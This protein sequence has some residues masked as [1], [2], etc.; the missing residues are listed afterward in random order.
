MTYFNDIVI[1]DS[2]I[3]SAKDILKLMEGNNVLADN[4]TY[5]CLLRAFAFFGGI[6]AIEEKLAQH[7][8][9]QSMIKLLDEDILKVI[10]DLAMYGH[11]DKVDSLIKYINH[12]KDTW[13]HK[14]A[15]NMILHLVNYGLDEI[16]YKIL[17]TM[18]KKELNSGSLSGTGSF[19]VKHYVKLNRP[20]NTIFELCGRLERD[21][22]NTP[23]LHSLHNPYM[24]LMCS[25]CEKGSIDEALGVLN[26]L[27]SI[28]Y[29]ITERL[30]HPL[31]RKAG[32]EQTSWALLNA[33]VNRFNIMP[34]PRM[35]REYLVSALGVDSPVRTRNYLTEVGISKTAAESAI[36]LHTLEK[37]RL[38]DA[39]D[40]SIEY[41]VYI[42]PRLFEKEL[43]ECLHT[44]YDSINFTRFLRNYSE[45]NLKRSK[46]DSNSNEKKMENP[47]EAVGRILFTVLTQIPPE[48]RINIFAVI[49]NEFAKE[50][51]IISREQVRRIIIWLRQ[52]ATDE[53]VRLLTQIED[54]SDGNE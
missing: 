30:F 7:R 24:T 16:A 10:G 44:K 28:S 51:L 31:F 17:K 42:Y 41:E 21:G 18:D 20:V 54:K 49:L 25:L 19:L 50:K 38:K 47:R 3:R 5:T 22:K 43:I 53:I 13:Y 35:V 27:K 9:K 52:D 36:V 37:R 29:R 1:F 12:S 14:K 26:N 39:A 11:G 6:K 4:E 48:K 33:M 8:K 34:T 46:R 2:D 15:R 40:L 45:Q 23:S 32:S